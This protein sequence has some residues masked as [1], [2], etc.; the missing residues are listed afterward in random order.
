MESYNRFIADKQLS[1]VDRMIGRVPQP[2]MFGGKR[3]REHPLPGMSE[4]DYAERTLAVNGHH[5]RTAWDDEGGN[6]EELG[7]G[8]LSKQFWRDFG[9]GFKQGFTKTMEV[10]LP[11]VLGAGGSGGVRKPRGRIP[12]QVLKQTGGAVWEGED[13]SIHS[14]PLMS[15]RRKGGKAN[16]FV[17]TMKKIGKE[18]K[19]VAKALK[20]VAEK[21]FREVIVPEG[22]KM[23]TNYLAGPSAST[24]VA[25]GRRRRHSGGALIADHPEEFHSRHYPKGLESYKRPKSTGGAR[26]ARGALVSKLMK[27]HGM[28]LGEASRHIK[29]NGLM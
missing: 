10:G 26:S 15:S 25:S 13:G 22:K 18:L 4:Y 16:K 2:T 24:A 14:T 7:G 19:P 21:V 27:Q 12:G 9:H 3:V 11:L 28:T 23:L 6:D 8:K 1:S 5:D 20:P 29:E 17:N